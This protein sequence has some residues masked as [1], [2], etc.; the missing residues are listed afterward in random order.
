M[1][2]MKAAPFVAGEE[3]ALREVLTNLIFNAVDAMP[4]GGRIT[5]EASIEG[6]DAVIRV[7]DTGTGMS[8]TVRQRCLE[9]FFSTKG[10]LGT[11]PRALHGLRNYRAPSRQIG[12]R[13]RR[14]PGNHLHHSHTSGR[15]FVAAATE[16]RAQR[17]K[18]IV[19][20]S[21]HRR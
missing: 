4:E 5:L 2:E 15:K 9:P 3:S 6:D 12:N 19:P 1:V 11:G 18:T 16:A 7:R 13:I 8:E 14:R 10:E 21:P 20:K 17:A